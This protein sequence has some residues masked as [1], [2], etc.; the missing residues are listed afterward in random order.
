MKR[1]LIE[2][3]TDEE[4]GMRCSMCKEEKPESEFPPSVFA[5]G[6]GWCRACN[7]ERARRALAT[8]EGREAAREASRRFYSAKGPDYGRGKSRLHRYG[9]TEEAFAALIVAQ[10]GQCAIC[11]T[12]EPGGSGAWHVDHDH[13][14]CPGRVTCGGKCIRGLLCNRCNVGV[15]MFLDNAETLRAA[16]DYLEKRG[17]RAHQFGSLT[18][19]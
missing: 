7:R 6:S 14:C 15:G 5:R 4:A 2:V 19:Q 9:L 3:T 8:P 16:A 11:G 17:N 12:T 13:A 1:E 18:A 10:G